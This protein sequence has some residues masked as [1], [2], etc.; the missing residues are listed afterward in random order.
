VK[1]IILLGGFDDHQRSK[2]A[3]AFKEAGATVIRAH[4]RK[5]MYS[6]PFVHFTAALRLAS[7]LSKT[8]LVVVTS[9]WVDI[10]SRVL[11]ASSIMEMGTSKHKYQ[12]KMLNSW[13]VT[14]RILDRVAL[15]YGALYF[16]TQGATELS[17]A[18][19]R[20]FSKRPGVLTWDRNIA[21]VEDIILTLS[22]N[23]CVQ[24]DGLDS[25]NLNGNIA[26]ADYLLV[27]DQINP[28]FSHFNHWP[29]HDDSAS[30]FF[31]T[32]ILQELGVP[33]EKIAWSNANHEKDSSVIKKFLGRRNAQVIALGREATKGLQSLGITPEF[34]IPHPSWAKRFNKRD[35]Y[36][37]SLS[38]IFQ[39]DNSFRIQLSP[40]ECTLSP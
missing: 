24:P 10:L 3:E 12:T 38:A 22:I 19:F 28:K 15:R 32:S 23:R 9:S 27:G 6:K 11:G 21:S 26:D 17:D 33:E 36:L 2:L 14:S 40:K 7:R 29:F 16:L 39:K 1:G 13:I 35:E 25:M 4:G 5:S 18:A 34:S 30:A 20:G 37:Q 8:K 31:I